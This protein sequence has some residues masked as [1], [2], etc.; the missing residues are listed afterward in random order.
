VGTEY[1][2]KLAGAEVPAE[3]SFEFFLEREPNTS[4]LRTFYLPLIQQYFPEYEK[5]IRKMFSSESTWSA[6]S[7]SP[8]SSF[9]AFVLPC[10]PLP[11]CN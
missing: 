10:G 11:Q 7:Y 9:M 8:G 6:V 1:K 2:Q 5:T 3:K 4:I